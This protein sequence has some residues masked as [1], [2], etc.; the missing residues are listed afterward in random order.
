MARN[1]DPF[2]GA[3]DSLPAG[4]LRSASLL[5]GEAELEQ[6][7]TEDLT[8]HLMAGAPSGDCEAR[9]AAAL[10][11]AGRVRE[12]YSAGAERLPERARLD[13]PPDARIKV[14]ASA[15]RHGLALPAP[16]IEL[17][18]TGERVAT[19]SAAAG[20]V[21]A[22]GVKKVTAKGA[23]K[24]MAKAFTKVALSKTAGASAGAGQVP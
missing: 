15:T 1:V 16:A 14:V 5:M 8:R 21:A 23:L 12:I 22:L 2:L 10:A 13:V 17:T 6:R 4:Y 11:S 24:A 7:L 18:T 19:R 9:L 20:V 3:N